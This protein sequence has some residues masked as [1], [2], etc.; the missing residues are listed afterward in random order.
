MAVA[1]FQA[2]SA[3]AR[4]PRKSLDFLLICEYENVNTNNYQIEN[5]HI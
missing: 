3:C 5:R 1:V 2:F 4:P